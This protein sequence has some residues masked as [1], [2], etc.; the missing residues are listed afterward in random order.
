MVTFYDPFNPTNNTSTDTSEPNPAELPTAPSEGEDLST[1]KHALLLVPDFTNMLE[2]ATPTTPLNSYL[3]LGAADSRAGDSTQ[4]ALGEDLAA[5]VAGF[6]DD[7]RDRKNGTA[8]N[9]PVAPGSPPGSSYAPPPDPISNDPS[10]P[11]GV[12]TTTNSS[13]NDYRSGESARLHSKGGWRDHSDGNRITTTRGDKVEVIRG[14]YKLLV[15]GRT[16]N[17]SNAEGFDNSGGWIDSDGGDL[18]SS[19]ASQSGLNQTWVYDGT[20]WNMTVKLGVDGSPANLN[21]KNETWVNQLDSSTYGAGVNTKV[22]VSGAINNT[23]SAA[24]ITNVTGA[25][26][27]F[28]ETGAAFQE[29]MQ[30]I[31]VNLTLNI[32]GGEAEL[33]LVAS[34]IVLAQITP[35]NI[36]E[37]AGVAIITDQHALG[38]ITTTQM[39]GGMI[40]TSQ[41]TTGAMS[42]LQGSGPFMLTMQASTDVT[43]I[44]IAGDVTNDVTGA[45]ITNLSTG[46]SIDTH[47]G[48]HID[49]HPSVHVDNHAGVHLDL[50]LGVH[51]S[52]KDEHQHEL[53][54]DELS[55]IM[56]SRMNLLSQAMDIT[57][58]NYVQM[59]TTMMT[60]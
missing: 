58:T 20:R 26:N 36:L 16:D 56:G 1:G 38:A 32:M 4:V 37:Q 22:A 44:V 50:H 59:A 55:T 31:G 33:D 15:L 54:G 19:G 47:V 42:T 51:I 46:V 12:L 34:G 57:S 27:I 13:G 3:R 41:L 18:G 43:N 5:Y 14:N 40:S 29:T 6:T 9:S 17:L 10:N 35:F 39:A 48:P 21:V 2:S 24:S 25:G 30:Q 7:S 60:M 49:N 28:N 53:A 11:S 23:N 8:P 52:S 45:T